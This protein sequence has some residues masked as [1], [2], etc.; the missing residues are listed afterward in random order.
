MIY[1]PKIII[2]TTFVI[3]TKKLKM[4]IDIN[5]VVSLNYKLSNHKSG[6]HIEE[7]NSEN[8]LVFLFGVGQLMPEFEDNLQGKKAGDKFDFAIES[9]NAYGPYSE[10]NIVMIPKTVFHT[11][12]GKFND[13]EIK[14]DAV[15]PMSDNEGNHMR[16]IV[17]EINEE[18]VKM[19][20]NHP[21]AGYDLHFTGDIIAVRE[22]TKDELD[23]GHVHGEGGHQH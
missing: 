23:H 11:E 20:F 1:R 12:E 6:A 13:E 15:V 9:A 7:T 5:S 4:T 16:G 8:P 22:A 14:V 17:R 19:D 10:D 21:L 3:H 2:I 18:M